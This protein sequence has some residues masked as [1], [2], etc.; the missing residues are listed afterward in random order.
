SARGREAEGKVAQALDEA[1]PRLGLGNPWDPALTS[2]AQRAQAQREGGLLGRDSRG[3]GEQRQKDLHMLA[4]LERGRRGRAEV[5]DGPFD[6]VASAVGYGD[7][8][9]EYGIDARVLGPEAVAAL[10]QGSA[11]REPLVAGLDDWAYTLTVSG[12]QED[13]QTARRLLAAA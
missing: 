10:V 6:E 13:R 9:R 8:F 11:I 4:R 12:G 5:R 1:G 3:R 2:A 7:A